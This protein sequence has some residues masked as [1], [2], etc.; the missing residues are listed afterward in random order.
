MKCDF[1]FLIKLNKCDK[2]VNWDMMQN[3][4]LMEYKPPNHYLSTTY[5][6]PENLTF[7]DYKS[8]INICH[9]N[10][11]GNESEFCS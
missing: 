2:Y 4:E 1:S 6:K 3:S 10:M 7:A 11:L 9:T 5:L 8:R